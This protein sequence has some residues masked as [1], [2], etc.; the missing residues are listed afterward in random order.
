MKDMSKIMLLFFLNKISI[1]NGRSI[2]FDEISE[3]VRQNAESHRQR[4]IYDDTA[5]STLFIDGIET[6]ESDESDES[7]SDSK[8]SSSASSASAEISSDGHFEYSVNPNNHH[9]DTQY[10]HRHSGTTHSHDIIVRRSKSDDEWECLTGWTCKCS[11]SFDMFVGANGDAV[12]MN[13]RAGTGTSLSHS[14]SLTHSHNIP[15][16]A[17]SSSDNSRLA[18][19]RDLQGNSDQNQHHHGHTGMGYHHHGSGNSGSK[20]SASSFSG[21]SGSVKQFWVGTSSNQKDADCEL[22]CKSKY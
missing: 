22:N 6:D 8:S 14:H 13:I 16:S 3:L 9:D 12:G 19:R 18:V 15:S 17:S 11:G 20:Y 4:Q 5:S 21:Q 7:E 1:V 2:E 10:H